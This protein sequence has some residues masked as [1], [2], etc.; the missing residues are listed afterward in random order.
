[1]PIT[2]STIFPRSHRNH[3]DRRGSILVLAAFFLVILSVCVAFAI[4][5]GYLCLARSR[6]QNAADVAAMAAAW[7]LL[8]ER[9]LR[10]DWAREE[11]DDEARDVA[12]DYAARNKVCGSGPLLDRNAANHPNGDLV[13]G[14]F[15]SNGQMSTY[16]NLREQNAVFV[17]ISRT[18]ELNGPVNLFFAPCLGIESADVTAEAVATFRDGISGFR[19]TP[20]TG[21]T[22]LIPFAVHIDVWRQLMAGTV[23][24][25]DWTVD[26]ETDQVAGG[27]DGILELTFYPNDT[28][29][30]GNFGTL[31]IGDPNNGTAE[32]SNQIANGISEAD[33]AFQGGEIGV[34][35]CPGNPGISGGIKHGLSQMIGKPRSI[36]LYDTVS[37]SGSNSVYNVVGFAGMRVVDFWLG[38]DEEP[39]NEEDYRVVL[40]PAV[41]VDD[42]AI[43]G[44]SSSYSV[45]QPVVL[46]K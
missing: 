31:Q 22:S 3:R 41:V 11:L 23:G 42:A 16:G 33:L 46:A 7:E 12:I 39:E 6:A 34:G 44:D 21:N 14:R 25:D 18:T 24:T 26:P 38:D 15:D 8:D 4:D 29:S 40:Q 5:L 37:G 9:R 13:F 20:K 10:D 28:G 35:S 2:A 27:S 17:R 1:M 45:Y 36:A 19:A 30:S 32:L 43:A